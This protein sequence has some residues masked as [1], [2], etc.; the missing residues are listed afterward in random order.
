MNRHAPLIPHPA[1]LIPHP[2][3]VRCDFIAACILIF[4][5]VLSSCSS[6]EEAPHIDS[7]WMNMVSQPIAEAVCA[8]PGQT[9]CLHGQHLSDLKRVIVNGTDINLNTLYVYESDNY[10][11]FQL[12]S[13]VNT[14]GDNIRVVTKWGMADYS[15]I[16]RPLDEKPVITAFSTTTLV[17]GR[18]LTI[19]GTNLSGASS[20]ILPLAYDETITCPAETEQET[21]G[22]TVNVT[23][24]ADVTFATGRCA[25]VMEKTDEARGI[26]YTER[27]YS[28][29]VDFK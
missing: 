4:A 12:P 2:F 17:Q 28:D 7:V 8:Y 3:L 9:I 16:V 25:I 23:I 21:A 27:V 6:N 1:P 20:V 24:P 18:T 15:F 10:I 22:T 11:T 13:D 19:T 26:T 5:A 14:V 29:V